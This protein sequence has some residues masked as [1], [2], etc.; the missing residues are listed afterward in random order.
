MRRRLWAWAW[1]FACSSVVGVAHAAADG[2]ALYAQH[3]AACHQAEGQGT[4]GLAP[5]LKGEHWQ[6]LGRDRGYLPQVLVHGLSGPITVNG[7]R[8][9][10]SMP[11]FGGQLD[12]EALAAVA[13]HLQGFVQS[14]A[15]AAYTAAELRAV[16]EAGGSPPKSRERRAQALK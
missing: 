15:D 12:D 5:A 14:R 1:A 3:C 4:V 2:A 9:A 7:E 16:R 11:A 8:H 10:G 6:R 13:S